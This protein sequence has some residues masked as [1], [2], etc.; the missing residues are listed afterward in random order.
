[1]D[2]FDWLEF[3]SKAPQSRTHETIER[4]KPDDGP[5]FLRAANEMREAGYFKDAVAF[6]EKAIGHDPHVY[7][8]WSHLVDTLV[9]GGQHDTALKRIDSGLEAFK[10]VRAFYAPKALVLAH[11][12]KTHEAEQYL[13]VALEAEEPSWYTKSVEAELWLRRNPGLR[14]RYLDAIDAAIEFAGDARWEAHFLAGWML[15]DAEKWTLAAGHLTEACHWNP[16]AAI[17]WLRLGDC[18]RALRLYDQATFYYDRALELEP[19]HPLAQR[20]R[21]TTSKWIYGLMSLFDRR[22]LRQR[23]QQRYEKSR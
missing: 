9:R 15:L 18:F 3:D 10:N 14:D 11:L 5:S 12:G 17:T 19:S 2:R 8:A 21:K 20:R 4:T 7:S 23:W 6:Y 16:R 22:S 13:N 1:V